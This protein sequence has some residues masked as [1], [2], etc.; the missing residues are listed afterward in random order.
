M[1]FRSVH[2]SRR[3]VVVAAIPSPEPLGFS[4][5]L[6]SHFPF[7]TDRTSARVLTAFQPVAVRDSLLDEMVEQARPARIS[8]SELSV[9]LD[10]LRDRGYEE[11]PSDTVQGIVDIA[12]PIFHGLYAGAIAS[13]NMPYLTQR[14]ALM[15]RSAA[16]KLLSKAV[17][18]IS[19]ELGSSA[20]K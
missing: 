19:Q 8:R 4:V 12:Y 15:S 3:L 2:A 7:R 20:H 16:R 18:R 17:R 1:L 9:R 14:D 13:L 5:R 10:Q 6:G 11:V